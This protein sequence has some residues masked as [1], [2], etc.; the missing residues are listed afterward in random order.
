MTVYYDILNKCEEYIS[1]ALTAAK[2]DGK[3]NIETIHFK[4]AGPL[5]M[6]TQANTPAVGIHCSG[7]M[8]EGINLHNVRGFCEVVTCGNYEEAMT[9]CKTAA[10]EVYQALNETR[11]AI[12]AARKEYQEFSLL[13]ALS[14]SVDLVDI[15]EGYRAIAKIEFSCEWVGRGQ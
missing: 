2:A 8:P 13:K 7:I 5:K 1:A 10:S 9:A 11:G 6:F 15:S 14:L 12:A 4:V 3:V